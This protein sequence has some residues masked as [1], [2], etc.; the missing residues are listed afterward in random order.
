[1]Y[2]TGGLTDTLSSNFAAYI[3]D[4]GEG[5]GRNAFNGQYV[6]KTDDIAL[7]N[8]WLF[9][10][11]TATQVK[12]TL[13]YERTSFAPAYVPAPGTTP[14]GGPPYTGPTQ[15]LDGY[16]QPHGLTNQ[17]GVSLQIDHD[18]SFAHFVSITAYRDTSTDAA[19][20][21]ALTTDYD[22]TLNLELFETHKQASQE[23]QLRSPTDSA[24]QWVT[25]VYLFYA[26]A[27]WSPI[28]AEGGLLA[29]YSY[30]DTY[31]DQKSYSPAIFG[32]ATKKL[33]SDT[34]LTLGL[35]YT[36]ERRTFD[37]SEVLGVPNGP[38]ISAGST[39]A[40]ETFQKPTWR[41]SLDHHFTSDL[42]SYISY[43]RGFKSGGFND[44]LVPTVA[45][46]PET[47]DDYEIGSK[48]DLANHHLRIDMAAFY[49][50]YKNLQEVRYPDG[51]ED[52][53]NAPAARIYGLDFDLKAAPIRNLIAT[54][55]FEALHDAYTSF[56]D[57]PYSTPAPIPPG[58]TNYS[59][60]NVDGNHLPQ[61]PNWTADFSLEYVVPTAIGDMTANFAYS[62]DGGW[63]AE[64]DN[65][66]RQPAYSLI[67]GQI[68]WSSPDDTMSVTFWGHN[69]LNEAYLTALDSQANGDFGQ[70]APPRTFGVTFR[71]NF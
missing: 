29:P 44:S 19:F 60:A 24:V 33:S 13:D 11:S 71:R 38:P 68:E 43:N 20:D 15:G 36:A 10:P 21:G 53:F 18:L 35:R 2:V 27:A 30:A 23:F 48:A 58:G 47:L 25:G 54:M 9:S 16:Y 64:A 65:R 56:P 22:Y 31:S 63:Y 14:L 69:L 59:T 67:N 50:N 61:T 12:L 8:K 49:Y 42:M 17:G 6:N 62:Y 32:Q 7:R 40:Q 41:I 4:Q 57:A 66:L 55:G 26:D 28:V 39:E 70:Y 3:Q 34:N 37:G 52:I 1:M 5:F 45:F 46:S 51:I